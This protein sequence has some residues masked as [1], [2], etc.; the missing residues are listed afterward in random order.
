MPTLK[1]T[2][3]LSPALTPLALLI[4]RLKSPN[5]ILAEK[6]STKSIPILKS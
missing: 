6:K 4:Y 1:Y 2:A 5:V 3:I